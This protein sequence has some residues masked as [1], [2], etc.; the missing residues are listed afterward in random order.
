METKKI[1]FLK[2]LN[3][4]FARSDVDEILEAVTDNIQWTIVGDKI[5]H[6]KEYAFCDI[7]T[8]SGFKNAKIQEMKSY[9][10]E[11]KK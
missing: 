11:L 1:E 7:Y 4:A 5:I 10:F 3:E 8:F 2:K 9:V 6:G